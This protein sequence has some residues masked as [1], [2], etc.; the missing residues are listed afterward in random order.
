M[1]ACI[2]NGGVW[3]SNGDSFGLRGGY[4]AAQLYVGYC[5]DVSGNHTGAGTI[6]LS[7]S[8][9]YSSGTTNTIYLNSTSDL[10]HL[11]GTLIE[12]AS[13][14]T[15]INNNGI[16]FDDGG[17]TFIPNSGT[18]YTCSGCTLFGSASITGTVPATTAYALTSGWGTSAV[19]AV[20]GDARHSQFTITTTVSGSAGPVLTYTFPTAN[21]LAGFLAAPSC[22]L[23]QVGGTFSTLSNP[24]HSTTATADTITFAGTPTTSQTYTFVETCQ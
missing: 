24:S 8:S 19:S 11:Q 23:I 21:G 7:G 18:M 17:N 1:G 20:T 15:G 22:T 10:L 12:S 9:V 13:G 14:S 6:Y 4:G 2:N 3:R 5:T 16:V